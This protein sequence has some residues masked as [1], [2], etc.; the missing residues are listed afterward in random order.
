MMKLCVVLGLVGMMV[1][2]TGCDKPAEVK[3]TAIQQQIYT[4]DTVQVVQAEKKEV[5][6]GAAKQPAVK[7]EADKQVKSKADKAKKGTKAAKAK[8]QQTAKKANGQKEAAKS[9][10]TAVKK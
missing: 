8:K 10:E 5:K 7:Q 4:Q 6:Q 9:A 1:V 3:P 2:F